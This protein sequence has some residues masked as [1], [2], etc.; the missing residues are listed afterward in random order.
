MDSTSFLT[1]G[2]YNSSEEPEDD[3]IHITKGYSRDHRPDLNQVVL[4]LICERQAGIPLLMETLNGNNSDKDSFSKTISAHIKQMRNDFKLEYVIAD[5]ALYVA[6]TLFDMGDF[7]WISRVP[8]TLTLA[9]D[10]I[11]A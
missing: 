10:I 7:L 3:V 5:S 4:Q 1:F 6:D 9:C 2:Q 11:L 8:E